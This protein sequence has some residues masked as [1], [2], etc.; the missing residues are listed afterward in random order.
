MIDLK[1]DKIYKKYILIIKLIEDI[2]KNF[3]NIEYDL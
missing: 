1:I 2:N 3:E